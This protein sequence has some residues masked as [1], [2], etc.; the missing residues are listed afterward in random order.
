MSRL[1]LGLDVSTSCTGICILDADVTEPTNGNH[2][3]LLDR[4][5]FKK[6]KSFWDKADVVE[7]KL[8]EFKNSGITEFCLEEPLLGFSKGMSS[9]ATI[10]T[11]MRFNGIASYIARCIFGT[12]PVY[13]AA[14]SARKLAGVKFGPIRHRTFSK[15]TKSAKLP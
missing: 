13:I 3:R 5:E 4:I 7:K 1:V 12:D 15:Q 2:I 8:S 6:C 11:L 10:T 9:A 14:A